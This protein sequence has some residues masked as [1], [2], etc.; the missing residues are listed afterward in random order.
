MQARRNELRNELP[1]SANVAMRKRLVW[2]G[3]LRLVTRVWWL[4]DDN[5][6]SVVRFN[7]RTA[8]DLQR[9]FASSLG[10]AIVCIEA[11]NPNP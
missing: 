6:V 11:V 4:Y 2:T 7:G 1:T 3:Y 9:R 5:L 8:V 10:P